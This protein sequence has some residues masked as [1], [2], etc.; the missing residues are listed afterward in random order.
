MLKHK[1]GE[2]VI[3][4]IDNNYTVTK[5]EGGKPSYHNNIYSA[6]IFIAER[7]ADQKATLGL[8]LNEYRR[9][10]DELKELLEVEL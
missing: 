1:I 2:F 5:G 4:R 7:C 8:W 9:I 3:A 6:C 10:G